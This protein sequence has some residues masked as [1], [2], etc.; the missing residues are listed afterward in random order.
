[1]TESTEHDQLVQ[2]LVSGMEGKGL[3]VT[4]IA[5]EPG[6]EPEDVKLGPSTHKP[7]VV[8]VHAGTGQTFIGEAETEDS[9]SAESG[10]SQLRVFSSNATWVYIMVP[11]HV[12]QMVSA[13]KAALPYQNI[14]YMSPSGL[15]V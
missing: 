9:W 15:E 12:I 4:H 14:T 6:L 3:T 13:T 11:D 5:G 8:A 2:A 7:D 10:R 1:M